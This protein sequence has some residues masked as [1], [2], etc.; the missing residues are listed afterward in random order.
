[1]LSDTAPSTAATRDTEPVRADLLEGREALDSAAVAWASLLE[2]TGAASPFA[3]PAWTQ[4][5]LDSFW[6]GGTVRLVRAWAGTHAIGFAPLTEH[7]THLMGLPFTVWQTP[8][9]EHS[10]R[11]E[12]ALGPDPEVAIRAIWDRLRAAPGWDLLILPNLVA[13]GLEDVTLGRAAEADG[14]AVH[15]VPSLQSP[16][17]PVTGRGER[18]RGLHPK[19]RTNLRRR[20][21]KLATHGA[22]TL[23]RAEGGTEAEAVLREGLAL[24]ASGWKGRQGTAIASSASTMRFYTAF[25]QRAEQQGWLSLY[26]LRL[27]ERAVAFHYGLAYGRRYG[28]LKPAYDESLGACSPGHLLVEEVLED[29]HARGFEEF[30]FLGP[31]MAWK[32]DWT[33]RT[34]PHCCTWLI[35]PSLKGR[36]LA[37]RFRGARRAKSWLGS[38]TSRG[39]P[40]KR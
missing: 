3:H 5:W 11:T 19:F 26:L 17:L 25:A 4:V 37:A 30:D 13:G 29:L 10:P 2:G 7:H 35:R 39:F 9:N 40:W 18:E 8:A 27:G 36:L 6:H 12:W 20:R 38:V 31:D 34:R 32:R 16:W 22:L 24:E 28:V 15:R 23:V 33:G 21:R 14:F 1:M